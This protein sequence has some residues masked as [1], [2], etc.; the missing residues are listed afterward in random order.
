MFKFDDIVIHYTKELPLET[1]IG[2]GTAIVHTPL[3]LQD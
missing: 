1:T 3:G 2:E